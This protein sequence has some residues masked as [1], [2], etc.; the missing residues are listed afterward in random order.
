[1]NVILN[2]DSALKCLDNNIVGIDLYRQMGD[3]TLSAYKDT[4]KF[5][6]LEFDVII[7]IL[8]ASLP[9]GL[10]LYQATNK[11]IGF[12]SAKRREDLSIEINYKNV[13]DFK[14][15]LIVD[16]WVASGNTVVEVAKELGIKEI[17]LF[18]LI[19][20][21]QALELIKPKNYIVGCVAEKMTKEHYIIPPAPFKPRD[22]GNDLFINAL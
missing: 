22:G 4:D 2:S 1:M 19:A 13:P 7:T 16:G 14:R 8:R 18:G 12:I 5:G 21:R 10:A 17:D 3:Y 9:M 6:G 20:S 11:K 15:P